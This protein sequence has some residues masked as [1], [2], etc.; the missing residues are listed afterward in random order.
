MMVDRRTVDARGAGLATQLAESGIAVIAADL[1]GHGRSGPLAAAGGRWS[2]DDLV[3]QDTPALYAYARAEFPDLP[4]A[5]VGHSLFG[6]IALAHAA[7]HSDGADSRSRG[8]DLLVLIA[9][10]LWARRW[11]PRLSRWLR[12]RAL[13]EAS[14]LAVRLAGYLPARRLRMGNCDE[15]AGYWAQLVD[16]A[17]QNEWR[18]SDGFS[19]T[20]ALPSVS[21]PLLA[22]VG[23]GDRLLCAAECERLFLAPI[24][25][26]LVEEVG[27]ASGL[28]LDPDHMA[29]VTDDR[30]RPM[31]DRVARFVL[32]GAPGDSHLAGTPRTPRAKKP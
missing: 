28:A 4:L 9:S 22:I 15:S 32:D 5:A 3:E 8:A 19:Y 27:R 17:R 21:Q 14:V 7:R 23:A 11:E 16:C 26:A 10:G 13:L 1:R 12:K 6:H 30:C 29:L 2:Y 20:A 31:W 25:H 24:A 18:A